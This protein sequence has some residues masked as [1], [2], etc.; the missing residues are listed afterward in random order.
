[1]EVDLERLQRINH[2][3]KFIPEGLRAEVKLRHVDVL[4]IAP[5][6]PLESIAERYIS[7]LPWPIR[8]MLRAVGVLRGSGANLVSYLLFERQHC[9]ALIDLGYEDALQRQAEII[10]FLSPPTEALTDT[11]VQ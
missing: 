5:S 4:I 10:Q 1:M 3:V 8:L 9:R 2:T 6:Q 11:S 7:H